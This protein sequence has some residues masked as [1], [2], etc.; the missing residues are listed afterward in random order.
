MVKITLARALWKEPSGFR[1]ERKERDEYVFVHFLTPAVINGIKYPE[2]TF[3]I[4]GKNTVRSFSSPDTPLIHDWF[5]A[6]GLRAL[7]EKYGIELNKPYTLPYSSFITEAVSETEFEVLGK[8][9]CYENI[10]NARTELLFAK[11]SRAMNESHDHTSNAY[12]K[13]FTALRNEIMLTYNDSWSTEKMAARVK[14]SASKFYESYKKIFGI[15]PQKDLQGVRIEH[16]KNLLMQRGCSVSE[17]AS[18]VGYGNVYHFIRQF[19]KLCN[20]TPGAYARLVAE[21]NEN[22]VR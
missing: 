18:A 2:K 10:I 16:A 17:A 4:Y 19:K 15:T 14:L 20:V 7:A 11:I 5:H 1:I 13:E 12:Y 22:K 21:E 6:R 9:L 8:K 3:I